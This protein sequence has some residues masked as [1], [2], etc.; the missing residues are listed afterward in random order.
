MRKE[1]EV[2]LADQ[3]CGPRHANSVRRDLV[4][5]DEAALDVFDPKV[6]GQP[7]DQGLQ[8]QAL[9]RDGV[10]VALSSV[11]SSCVSTQPPPGIGW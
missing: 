1:F 10:R 8:R 5:D 9:V 6:V 2:G 11:M 7:V 3:V 4:G